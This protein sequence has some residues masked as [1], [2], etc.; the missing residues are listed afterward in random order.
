MQTTVRQWKECGF[1]VARIDWAQFLFQ[2]LGKH[3]FRK[4]S[5]PRR[6]ESAG[7]KKSCLS[8]G[9]LTPR[10]PVSVMSYGCSSYSWQIMTWSRQNPHDNINNLNF[11]TTLSPV[12]LSF[13]THMTPHV[14]LETRK[15]VRAARGCSAASPSCLSRG[16]FSVDLVLLSIFVSL[17]FS[18]S[19]CSFTSELLVLIFLAPSLWVRLASPCPCPPMDT[20]SK[21]CSCRV[22]VQSLFHCAPTSTDNHYL[23]KGDSNKPISH[24]KEQGCGLL[25]TR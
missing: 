10:T 18:G 22:T 24:R 9:S 19:H 5:L 8:P 11:Q 7:K 6:E 3:W 16:C 20:Q 2:A 17:C 14:H 25:Y 23:R 15:A 12:S 21:K 1:W 13:K 4:V